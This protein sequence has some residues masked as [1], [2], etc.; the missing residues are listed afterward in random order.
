VDAA[1]DT[2]TVNFAA[3]NLVARGRAVA[4][5]LVLAAVIALASQVPVGV[6]AWSQPAECAAVTG[7]HH[8][9]LVVQHGDGSAKAYCI[10]FS[11]A[12]LTGEQVLDAS[13]IPYQ[14]VSFGSLSK[15]VCQV[16]DEPTTFPPECWTSQSNF[17]ALFVARAGG[18]WRPASV[19]ISNLMLHDGDSEG[20]RYEPQASPILPTIYGNCPVATPTPKPTPEPTAGATG[21][22]RPV[23]TPPPA[24]PS[25]PAGATS[26]PGATPSNGS[27]SEPATA[28]SLASAAPSDGP[29]AI[30]SAAA[31]ADPSAGPL[32]VSPASSDSG[33]PSGA[34]L[35]LLLG[36]A[37]IGG[38]AVLA[39]ARARASRPGPPG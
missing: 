36:L 27:S 23:P 2:L 29:S 21:T 30:A 1:A 14:T 7:S 12:S 32:V 15:A 4:G 5:R 34:P 26:D 11:G 20:L 9:A 10:T 6:L 19:G 37:L 38:L 33:S 25:S 8:V 35:A 13:K 31:S 17:W 18:Q 39:I 22:P 3:R 16:D 28:E 24:S